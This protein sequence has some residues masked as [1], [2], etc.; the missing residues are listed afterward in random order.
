MIGAIVS[1][2]TKPAVVKGTAL[3]AK[4]SKV[5]GRNAGS[6]SV[7]PT[8]GETADV[9]IRGGIT[10]EV[11]IGVEQIDVAAQAATKADAYDPTIAN[12]TAISR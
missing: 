5:P 3:V 9:G 2:T 11:G 12:A 1:N 6:V 10:S 4:P 7:L 8:R